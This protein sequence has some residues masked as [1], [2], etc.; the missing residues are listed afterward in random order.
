MHALKNNLHT[1]QFTHLKGVKS[2]V[3]S[4]LTV[5]CNLQHNF[6][7][8]LSPPQK[9]SLYPLADLAFHAPHYLLSHRQPPTTFSPYVFAHSGP[10]AFLS[11]FLPM[12]SQA[13]LSRTCKKIPADSVRNLGGISVCVFALPVH[14]AGPGDPGAG[15]EQLPRPSSS[16]R[17]GLP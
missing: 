13:P 9:E 12:K 5:L 16:S 2:V 7:T 1:I 15:E 4:I 10:T 3:F 6:R 14:P 11:L 8:F 17:P